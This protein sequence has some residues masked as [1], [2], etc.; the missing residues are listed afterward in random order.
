MA[1]LKVNPHGI[2]NLSDLIEFNKTCSGEEVE[3]YDQ[4]PALSQISYDALLTNL[5][6][7][8]KLISAVNINLTTASPE[9]KKLSAAREFL[10]TQ[11]TIIGALDEVKNTFTCAIVS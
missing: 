3:T 2:K 10:G 4:V 8:D 11:G 6:R 9:Y 5:A 7:K 1:K